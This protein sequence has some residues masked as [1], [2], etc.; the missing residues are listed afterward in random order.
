MSSILDVIGSFVIGAILVIA[1]MNAIFSIHASSVDMQKQ[2]LLT[3]VSE[4]ITSI[5]T[6]YLTKVGVGVPK[7]SAILS[8]SGRY[9]FNF[10]GRESS[11]TG[12][13][14]NF[15]IAQGDSVSNHGFPLEVYIDGNL[16]MGPFWL[17]KRM[18]LS[19]YDES[20]N[21]IPMTNDLI[22][23]GFHDQVRSVRVQL[24]FF[25]D[26]F[27]PNTE[28]KSLDESTKI[29]NEVVFW[30]YFLNMYLQ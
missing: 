1:I 19:Y 4:D 17:S 25:Y 14:R 3:E 9:K 2:M 7:T 26:A 21:V 24:S 23:A 10:L 22:S 20:S 30:K 6:E 5:L 11:S 28:G 27:L 15:Y 18:D 13:V 16:E 8:N 29:K 12:A